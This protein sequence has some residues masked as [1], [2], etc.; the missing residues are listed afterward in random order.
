MPDSRL[1]H[2]FKLTQLRSDS[3]CYLGQA[4]AFAAE[5]MQT[6]GYFSAAVSV[7]LQ[8]VRAAQLEYC[9]AKPGENPEVSPA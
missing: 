8:S 2:L 9:A 4:V 6:H 1:G 5:P 3:L 7:S